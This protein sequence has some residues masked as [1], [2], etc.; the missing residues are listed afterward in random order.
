[1]T[2]KHEH[3]DANIILGALLPGKEKFRSHCKNYLTRFYG[4]IF[5]GI[6]VI[7][8]GEI[9]RKIYV[10]FVKGDS[11]T[12]D[13]RNDALQ[14]IDRLILRRNIEIFQVTHEDVKLYQELRGVENRA[15]APELLSLAIAIRND[16]EVFVTADSALFDSTG[17]K[18][19]VNDNYRISI[20]K[21]EGII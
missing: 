6:S 5:G 11:K 14:F 3:F 21:P 18:K 15:D 8:L 4:D 1:M 9:H 20:K 13:A 17:L 2:T 10:T 16:A 7:T 12:V 19:Y